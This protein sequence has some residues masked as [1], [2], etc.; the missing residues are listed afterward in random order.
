[1]ASRKHAKLGLS[2]ERCGKEKGDR[3]DE[4]NRGVFR[5]L[6]NLPLGICPGLELVSQGSWLPGRTH[7]L[8]RRQGWRLASAEGLDTDSLICL[9]FVALRAENE[10]QDPRHARLSLR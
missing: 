5:A 10:T 3:A 8:P 9:L 7:S 1:M 2:S 4:R 6:D